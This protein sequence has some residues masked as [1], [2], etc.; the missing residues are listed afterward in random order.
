M[1][2]IFLNRTYELY[3][4]YPVIVLALLFAFIFRNFCRVLQ[5]A[6]VRSG[7]SDTTAKVVAYSPMVL[8]LGLPIIVGKILVL[9]IKPTV[10]L[11]VLSVLVLIPYFIFLF[12]FCKPSKQDMALINGKNQKH[13]KPFKRD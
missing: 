11:L 7:K 9:I 10:L 12:S 8:F 2:V 13:N 6:A 3:W 4:G 1:D 5:K